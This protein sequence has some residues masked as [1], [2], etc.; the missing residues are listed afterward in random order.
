MRNITILTAVILTLMI[1]PT[2]IYAIQNPKDAGV[3]TPEEIA[4]A[5]IQDAPTFNFDGITS[6]LK[7]E[8]ASINKSN[9]PQYVV[10][11]GFQCLHGGYGDRTDMMVTQAITPHTAVL[12]VV[13]GKV[14]SAVIDGEW[15]EVAQKTVTEQAKSLIEAIALNWLINA[16]TFKFDGIVGSAKVVDSWQAMTFVAPSFWGVTIEFDC[17][18]AGYGDRSRQMLAQVV[19][20]HVVTVHVTE[21]KVTL[22]PIDDRWDELTQTSINNIY[23]SDIAKETATAWLYNCPTFKFDGIPETVKVIEVMTLRMMNTWD[24]SINFTCAYPGYGNRTGNVMYGHSQQHTIKI[25]VIEGQVTRAII[26]GKWDEI[27]QVILDQNSTILSPE[28]ARDLAINYVV[29]KYGLEPAVFNIWLITDITPQLLGVQKTLYICGEWKITVEN[30]VV[31]KPTYTVTVEKGSISW[32]GKV[33]Q[34]GEIVDD[35]N[36]D[37]Q[38]PIYTPDIARKMCID[39]LMF[40]HPEVAGKIAIEWTEKNLVPEGIVGA[41]KIE[42]T[43]GGWT[44]IVS[45]PVVWKPTYT[46]SIAY[47]GPGTPFTWEGTVPQGGPVTET[48]FSK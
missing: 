19:T 5:F 8:D 6:T 23:T 27:N 43:S 16:P 9:P 18:H 14:T 34:T 37:V 7:V 28:E 45:A 4:L 13:D 3:K 24:V 21:G 29:K 47:S 15:D 46:V 26:D 20:H 17:L 48:S 33:E 31:W 40:S 1:V 2:S 41:T 22:A 42:Y 11:I 30:A 25:T 36:S 38:Q 35:T 12:T 10:A 32:T 39:Y 44:I